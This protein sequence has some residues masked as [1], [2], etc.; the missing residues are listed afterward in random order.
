M[1]DTHPK[2]GRSAEMA[3][4]LR[5]GGRSRYASYLDGASH[6]LVRGVDFTGSTVNARSELYRAARRRGLR[7]RVCRMSDRELS[8]EVYCVDAH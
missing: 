4:A 3:T 6:T 7:V 2:M 5:R 1:G 8:V